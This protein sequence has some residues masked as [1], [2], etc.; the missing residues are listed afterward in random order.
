MADTSTLDRCEASR[1]LRLPGPLLGTGR[2]EDRHPWGVN[3][4]PVFD[5][6]FLRICDDYWGPILDETG[7]MLSGDPRGRLDTK[8]ARTSSLAEHSYSGTWPTPFISFI[9]PKVALQE[10]LALGTS[11]TTEIRGALK[12]VAINPNTRIAKGLPI[13][14]FK[15][16]IDYYHV[17]GRYSESYTDHYLC[18]WEVAGDEV[19]G[20]W[21]WDELAKNDRWYEDIIMPAFKEHDQRAVTNSATEGVLDLSALSDGRPDTLPGDRCENGA[22]Q[23]DAAVMSG[24]IGQ[25]ATDE[26]RVHHRP[27]PMHGPTLEALVRRAIKTRDTADVAMNVAKAAYDELREYVTL[28]R[29]SASPPSLC[30]N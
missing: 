6:P 18:L 17:S 24:G 2:E 29:E 3:R 12:I 7:R 4:L 8:N 14:N 22:Q 1:L 27:R 13:L 10:L 21:D 20:Q 11:F 25:P 9:A 26:H 30:S 28:H 16:E 19:I 15:D 23:S 5:R